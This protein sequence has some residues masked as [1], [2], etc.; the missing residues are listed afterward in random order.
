M[1]SV[2]QYFRVAIF[3]RG[4]GHKARDL[5]ANEPAVNSTTCYPR[6]MAPRGMSGLDRSLAAS[7]PH[8][9]L[10]FLSFDFYLS[11]PALAPPLTERG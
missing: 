3:R 8:P 5:S 2:A 4:M 10:P 7:P 1:H 11:P 6:T 9:S